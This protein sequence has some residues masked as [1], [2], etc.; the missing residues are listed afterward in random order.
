MDR[1]SNGDYYGIVRC[2]GGKKLTLP[3]FVRGAS[4]DLVLT[5]PPL[6]EPAD[7]KVTLER[8]EKSKERTSA[9]AGS[10]VSGWRAAGPYKE[11]KPAESSS[12]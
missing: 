4:E 6:C 7:L 10:G 2:G 8:D 3:L 9:S 11:E 1:R 5:E 12:A